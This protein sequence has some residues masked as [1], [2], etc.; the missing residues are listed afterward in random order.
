MNFHRLTG[1]AKRS[2][3]TAVVLFAATHCALADTYPNRPIK[4]VVPIGSGTG[5]DLAARYFA[6]GLGKSLNVPVIVDNKVGAAG[7]IGTDAVA[8]AEPDGHTLLLTFAAHYINQ[9]VMKTPFD[10]VRDFEPIAGL[11]VTALVLVTGAASPYK[12]LGDVLTVA[13][14]KPD[15][16]SYASSGTGGVSHMA[17]ALLSKHGWHRAK[18]H[19]LQ[20]SKSGSHRCLHR[21]R[22]SGLCG[23]HRGAA[24][25][26]GR[27]LARTRRDHAD[28][29]SFPAGHP[30]HFGVR[31]PR[32]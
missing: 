28:S 11:N 12:S 1:M 31:S 21:C 24:A 16:L 9:W 27:S 13:K 3:A 15:S 6:A 10:A 22:G 8:K 29:L 26:P 7:V 32:L 30:N 20:S 2:L 18:S 17:G 19:S 4:I 23:C 14:R 5:S 25:A